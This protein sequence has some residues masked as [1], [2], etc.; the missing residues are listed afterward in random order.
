MGIASDDL[1]RGCSDCRELD[2]S[3]A[4]T[5]PHGLL[6]LVS[7]TNTLSGTREN[8]LCESCGQR[9]LRF[10]ATQTSPMPSDRWR[11]G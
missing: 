6:K 8:F 4:R 7:S 9:M 3:L 2:R 1:L 10:K 5:A 11:V